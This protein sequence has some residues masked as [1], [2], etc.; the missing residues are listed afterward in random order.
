LFRFEIM[1]PALGQCEDLQCQTNAH[2]NVRLFRCS[3]HCDRNLCLFHLN[4]HNVYYEQEKKQNSIVIN[5]LQ[6]C[7]TVYQTLFEKQITAYRE[8]VRQASTILLQNASSLVPSEQIQ[9]VLDR[10]QE[11]IAIYQEEKSKIDSICKI[12]FRFSF[13]F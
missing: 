10:I 5:E 8:L 6:N 12:F 7:L 1:L 3:I 4:A 11:A 2:E 9:T 13:D